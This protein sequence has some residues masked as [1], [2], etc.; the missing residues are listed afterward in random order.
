MKGNGTAVERSM[1]GKGKSMKRQR[2]GKAMKKQRKGK[3]KKTVINSK[4]NIPISYVGIIFLYFFF[5]GRIF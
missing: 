1:K 3:A 2:K 4:E 5:E